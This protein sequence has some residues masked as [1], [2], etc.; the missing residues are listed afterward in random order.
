MGL[1]PDLETAFDLAFTSAQK[2]VWAKEPVQQVAINLVI[3]VTA[4][5]SASVGFAPGA[6]IALIAIF[7]IGVAILRVIV[8]FLLGLR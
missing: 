7:L 5:L 1:I 6:V 8:G 4:M 2:A 3:L